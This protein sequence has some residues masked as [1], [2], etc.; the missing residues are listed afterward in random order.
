MLVATSRALL[1]MVARTPKATFGDVEFCAPICIAR[2]TLSST[3]AGIVDVASPSFGRYD[4]RRLY[5]R[6]PNI[7]VHV[8]A[9]ALRGQP[10][11]YRVAQGVDAEGSKRRRCICVRVL[12]LAK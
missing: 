9:H 11:L 7:V 3:N 5:P 8:L 4:G 2:V 6:W 10:R 1:D 12:L